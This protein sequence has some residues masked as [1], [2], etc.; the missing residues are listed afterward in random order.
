MKKVLIISAM[1]LAIATSMV[2]GTLAVYHVEL[3]TISEG[4]VIAKSFQLDGAGDDNFKDEVKIAP[5]ET[6]TKIFTVSNFKNGVATE[7]PMK[8]DIDVNLDA[9]AN[10]TAIPYLTA[11]V[12]KVTDTTETLVGNTITNGVG[13][14]SFEDGFSLAA[15]GQTYTY[16]VVVEWPNINGRNDTN[17]DGI[18]DDLDYAGET[19]GNTITVDVSG[20]QVESA[21]SYIK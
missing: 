19:Y 10:K 3:P 1:A 17:K 2:A 4:S 8:V 16:K 15:Q 12:Y 21:D 11:N 6:I 20:T 7:T 13:T 14:I 18:S 5:T 9:T